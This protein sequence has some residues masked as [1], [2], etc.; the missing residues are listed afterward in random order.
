[1]V[2]AIV[3]ATELGRFS[4]GGRK[5]EGRKRTTTNVVVRNSPVGL[6]YVDARSYF[7]RLSPPLFPLHR[8]A[9]PPPSC[10]RFILLRRLVGE[11]QPRQMSWFVF[12]NSP[13]GLHCVDAP[14]SSSFPVPPSSE[15]KPPTSLWK[16]EGR[17]QQHPRL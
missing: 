11:N 16:G 5:I 4:G 17:L 10:P 13:M 14:S 1:V 9:F 7:P 6:H 12:R 2:V 8:L 3:A 15:S